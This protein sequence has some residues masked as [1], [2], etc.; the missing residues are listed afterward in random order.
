MKNLILTELSVAELR[1]LFREEIAQVLKEYNFAQ[2]TTTEKKI[3]NLEE[4]ADYTGFS[5]SHLYKLTSSGQIPHFKRGKKLFFEKF[6]IDEWLLA[7]KVK[8]SSELLHEANQYLLQKR[9]KRS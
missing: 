6:A 9:R 3:Y 1:Q 7:N 4:T 2:A 8:D 5:K